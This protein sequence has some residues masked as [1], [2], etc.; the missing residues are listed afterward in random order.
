MYLYAGIWLCLPPFHM[1]VLSNSLPATSPSFLATV[2]LLHLSFSGMFFSPSFHAPLQFIHLSM[3]NYW[4][5]FPFSLLRS[6]QTG[7]CKPSFL[8]NYL[9]LLFISFSLF[10][11]QRFPVT[12]RPAFFSQLSHIHIFPLASIPTFFHISFDDSRLN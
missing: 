10:V 3:P 12:S 8:I 7:N 9:P 5:F 4:P 6:C 2:L 11:E 1:A